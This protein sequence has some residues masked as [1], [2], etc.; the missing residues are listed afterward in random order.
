[1]QVDFLH[2]LQKFFTKVVEQ[3]EFRENHIS[4]S[5]TLLTGR[6]KITGFVYIFIRLG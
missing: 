2:F 4:D 6:K 3:H 1:M 5:H